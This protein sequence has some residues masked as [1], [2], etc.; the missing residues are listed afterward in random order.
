MSTARGRLFGVGVGPGDPELMTIKAL[1]VLQ[2]HEPDLTDRCYLLLMAPETGVDVSV[3]KV[4]EQFLAAYPRVR[5]LGRLPRAAP[6]GTRW[7]YST[8]ETNLVGVLVA[9]ATRKPLA[10]YLSEKIWIPAGMEQKATWLVSRTGREIS[11]CCLQAA[12]REGDGQVADLGRVG[13]RRRAGAGPCR[14]ALEDHGEAVKREADMEG[15]QRL[16]QGA[17]AG[18]VAVEELRLGRNTQPGEVQAQ[19]AAILLRQA[20]PAD[21]AESQVGQGVADGG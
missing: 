1:R 7:N 3:E 6:A 8:G 19:H 12:P 9:A 11:G 21:D 5:I 15:R 16:G 4:S 18:V 14:D 10:T 2:A 20:A 13:A 17:P